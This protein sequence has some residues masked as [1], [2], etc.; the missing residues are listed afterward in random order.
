MEPLHHIARQHVGRDHLAGA[1]LSELLTLRP[2]H[3]RGRVSGSTGEC[4]RG[5]LSRTL[6]A[7]GSMLEGGV[8]EALALAGILALQLPCL[9]VLSW[10]LGPL[11]ALRAVGR[12]VDVLHVLAGGG[13][14]TRLLLLLLGGHVGLRLAALG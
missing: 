1:A 3:H 13:E 8:L 7:H 4:S 12:A 14:L 9:T 5:H 10:P 11:S 2:V 6:A